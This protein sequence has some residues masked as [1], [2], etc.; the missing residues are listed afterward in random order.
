MLKLAVSASETTFTDQLAQLLK[1]G[2]ILGPDEMSYS[3][4]PKGGYIGDDLGEYSRG[5]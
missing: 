4:L 5:Y 2:L 1:A 3:L